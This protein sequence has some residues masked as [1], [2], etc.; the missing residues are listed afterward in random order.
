MEGN[1]HERVA[2]LITAYIIGFITAFIAYG[3]TGTSAELIQ[4][5]QVPQTNTAEQTAS[6]RNATAPLV[7]VYANDAG[8]H[9]SAFSNENVLLSAAIDV[10]EKEEYAGM[11]GVHYA[12]PFSSVSP[13]QT[14]VYFCEQPTSDSQTCKPFIY[15]IQEE[16]VYPVMQGGERVEFAIAS[17]TATWG[18]DG[19][20]IY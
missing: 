10:S 15:S 6:V 8:L 16:V 13:D 4:I 20:L 11:D 9:V 14:H 5:V 17:H 18:N 2:L 3:L 1:R 12:V 7:D 19:E